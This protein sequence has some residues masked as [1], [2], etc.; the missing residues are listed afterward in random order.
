[1]I[2]DTNLRAAWHAVCGGL[3]FKAKAVR[4]VMHIHIPPAGS[5]NSQ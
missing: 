3:E 2:G 5:S 1:M 4:V